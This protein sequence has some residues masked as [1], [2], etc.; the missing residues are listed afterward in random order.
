MIQEL[1]ADMKVEILDLTLLLIEEVNICLDFNKFTK[2]C[3]G[4]LNVFHEEL[5]WSTV[6]RRLE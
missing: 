4:F 2:K 1:F 6:R 5:Q 3:L